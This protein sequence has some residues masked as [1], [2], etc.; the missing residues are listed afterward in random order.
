M[1]NILQ[2]HATL[3]LSPRP[4]SAPA[5]TLL[6]SALTLLA[7]LPA[8]TQA[9][10]ISKAD[11]NTSLTTT[12]AWTGGALP[13]ASDIACFGTSGCTSFTAAR[14]PAIGTG[15][16]S[17]LG[18]THGSSQ[19][20]T[21]G[22][23]G[24]GA[25]TLGASGIDMT[26]ATANFTWNAGIIG[27]ASQ[28]WNVPSGSRTLTFGVA[29]GTKNFTT[30]V[31][32]MTL[33]ITGAG[34]VS[35][36]QPIQTGSGAI[37]I[38][39]NNTGALIINNDTAA[40]A[41]YTYSGTMT[42]T[43][44]KLILNSVTALGNISAGTTIL[45]GSLDCQVSG[46]ITLNNEPFA[47]NGD[48]T[49]I[50]TQP[51][52]IGAGAVTL[53]GNRQ[54]TVTANT[55]TVGGVIGDGASSFSLTKAGAGTMTLTGNN[56]YKGGTAVSLG[57]LRVNGQVSPNSGTGTGAVQVNA[58]GTLSGSGRIAGAVTVA[59]NST[60]VLYPNSTTA[61]TLGGNLT[62]SGSSSTVELL[63]SAT[64][65]GANDKI[66]LE[67]QAVNGNGATI[68]INSAGTLDTTTDYVLID[69]GASGTIASDFNGAPTFVGTTPPN[70]GNYSIITSGKQV[71][72][73]YSVS[74]SPPTK[75]A[76][77][78]VPSS[79][80]KASPFSVTVQA[81]DA[82]NIQR[83]VTSD[84]TVSLTVGSGSGSLGGT[85]TGVIL[86][87]TDSVTISGVTYS[88]ADTMTLTATPTAGMTGLTPVT[89]GNIVFT[90]NLNW[91]SG[92]ADWTAAGAWY[93]IN[94][95]GAA[96]FLSG[97][98]VTLED[99][100]S[101]SSPITITLNSS[102]SPGSVTMN[103]TKDYTIS[104]SGGIGGSIGLTKQNTGTLTLSV[105]NTY[106][107]TTALNS[108][109]VNAGVNDGAG[110]GP[111][112][113]GGIISFGGGTLQHSAANT[114]DYSGRFST[115][116]SQAYKVDTAGQNVTWASVLT[117]SAGT[118]T[119]L[120]AGNL[121]LNGA[122]AY[123]GATTVSGGVIAVGNSSAFGTGGN[124]TVS[125]GA[126]V[127][128]SGTVVVGRNLI[129][130]GT[131]VSGTGA[132]RATSGTPTWGNA[133]TPQS[134]GVRIN[135]DSGATLTLNSSATI[136][137]GTANDTTVGGAGDII[138]SG[139]I[140]GG[141][142]LTKDGTGSF[143]QGAVNTYTGG[144][145]INDGT[146]V[147]ANSS[148][149]F[150]LA[151][152][153]NILTINN[154]SGPVTLKRGTQSG[155]TSPAPPVVQQGDVIF[156]P[157]NQNLNVAFVLN[158][159]AAFGWKIAGAN[160]KITTAATT[161]SGVFV[162]GNNTAAH[163]VEDG[164]PRSL[165]FDGSGTVSISCEN[166]ITGGVTISGGIV[167]A[168]ATVSQPFGPSS[169]TL[170]LAGGSLATGGDR[171][172][173]PIVN[174][175]NVTDNSTITVSTASSA[176]APGFVFSGAL[177]GT[178]GKTLTF[179]PNGVTASQAFAPRL[180][181]GFSYG[182]KIAINN[183]VGSTTLQ[184]YNTTGNDQT[185]SDVISGNGAIVRSASVSGTGGKTIFTA[186]NLYSGGTTITRGTLLVNNTSG[187][188]TGTGAVTVGSEG[189][190]GGTGSV[191]GTVTV[192]AGGTLAPGASIGTLTLS[193][194]PALGGTKVMEINNS[195]VPNADKLVVS[196][197]PLA[198]GGVL[199]VNNIGPALAGGETFDLFD[200]TGF[201]G[202]FTAINLPSLGA[203]LNWRTENLGVDGTIYINRAPTAQNLT[204][205]RSSGATLKIFKSDVMASVSDP[206]SG[207]SASYDALVSTGTQGATVTEDAAVIY[208]EPVND[209]NDTLQY[210]VKDTRGGTTTRNI[211]INVVESTGQAMTISV[212]GS[213]ATV[214]FAGIPSFS[215]QVQ[216][217]TNL[218][219]WVTLVT[220][221]APAN[222]LFEWVD[223]FSDL[224][225]VPPSAYYRLREP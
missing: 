59:N 175:L 90:Q 84:T 131:G 95:A 44:G 37:S 94:A 80:F 71:K 12:T 56:T 171:G 219:D 192:N 196:G 91:G 222:G 60:A 78:S 126:T 223:N 82:S 41:D 158:A 47:W 159:S 22:S 65:G 7:L 181:G 161:G 14:T 189:T 64:S 176:S 195:T 218:T 166:E 28:T 67:N 200:A 25:V 169:A 204:Y 16:F 3:N 208:Y 172:T 20:V 153:A 72:L 63:L 89:S 42:L 33:T 170:T 75:L 32:S 21:V 206:D 58:G 151:G 101:G 150:G 122:N 121:T 197:N 39:V 105:A 68:A 191:A 210:R 220:T 9:A 144:T 46:G 133:I 162:I 77:T 179:T 147:I 177:S 73:H 54:V 29:N 57:T 164:T 112:G 35:L 201:S 138:A 205:T 216:R 18:I 50:G 2:P 6:L 120:G 66:V 119:K 11:N 93:D 198:F 45:G 24:G 139:V 207:D 48:F 163:I 109:V 27:S 132:L 209:N 30:S 81:R 143:T 51:L 79:G 43:S 152:V 104:G 211:Q 130:N 214:S 155:A 114:V 117:S 213:T 183:S 70:P 34:N 187:S 62:C 113:N 61:L 98:T 188:G 13:T 193:A 124:V 83:N 52:N 76:Y 221:N 74:A 225:A 145:V 156:D 178:V 88:A 160:R 190:L 15:G 107:G 194:S 87:G 182:G 8:G 19:T 40:S 92:D 165:T 127:Q 23:T 217:S 185:F 224:G 128:V 96:T 168:G 202:A 108:G 136:N 110:N 100:H 203:G 137:T 184:L 49:F 141:G 199:T 123:T 142:I 148:G 97:D 212:S 149:T 125:S 17:C 26:G 157:N 106:S 174:P 118:L 186:A 69:A 103:A 167:R 10:T 140:S 134:A 135:A 116:A 31:A 99:T 215:Y 36:N 129:L 111:L 4:R 173:L 1:R 102:V 38:N 154:V 180:S 85:T 53:G 5:R 55:L 86:T 115:A 146:W